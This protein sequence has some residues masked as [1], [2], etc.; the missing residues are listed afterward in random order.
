MATIQI[1]R[2]LKKGHNEQHYHLP[3]DCRVC[4]VP[5]IIFQIMWIQ[6]LVIR[7]QVRK[8]RV[9]VLLSFRDENIT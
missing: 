7:T 3:R 5:K 9:F 6:A 8:K 2:V 1:L 4:S